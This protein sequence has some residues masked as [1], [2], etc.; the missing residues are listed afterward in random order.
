MLLGLILLFSLAAAAADWLHFRRARRARL[1]RLSLAWAAA[2]DAL[3]LAVVGMGLLCRDNPTPVVMASMWLF[4][5]WMATVLPRLAF[6]AFNFFGLRR[7]GLAAAA[8][9]FAALVIGVTAGRT[10]LRV[11]RTEVCSRCCPRR[12]TGCASCSSRTS[13]W[14]RSSRPGGS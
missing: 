5:S 2:T 11:S 1:R 10:S 12:S 4:W 3:P 13:I 9:V 6:Y 14:G 8:A 7:T